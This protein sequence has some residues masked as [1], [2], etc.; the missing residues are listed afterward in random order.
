MKADAVI[1]GAGIVGSTIA[2]ELSKYDIE[3]TVVEKEVD[4][5]FGSPTKA[6]TGVVHPGFDDPPGTTRAKHCSRGNA[7]WHEIAREVGA[8]FEEVGSLVVALKDEEIEVLE[9]LKH[10]GDTNG[11]PGLE[12]VTD[13][14]RLRRIEPNLNTGA[15]AALLAPTAA[16]TSPYELAM[17]MMENAVRN[18]VRTCFETEVTGITVKQDRVRGIQT[19]KGEI[20]TQFVVNAAGLWADKISS[21]V[22]LNRFTIHPR[23]G[24]YYIL[25]KK[26]G[27]LSRHVIFPTPSPISKGIVVT[28]TVE[29]NT[30]I[31]PNAQDIEDKRD[32]ATTRD[33][34]VE[35]WAG[36]CKLIP[37]IAD[38]RNMMVTNFCGLRPE[39]DTNDF[40]VGRSETI[41]GFINAAG[42]RSP[43]L[44][45]AP[46]VA[47]TIVELLRESGAELRQKSTFNPM[48]KP[49]DKP[50][51]ILDS[52]SAQKLIEQDPDY[53]YVVCRCEHV[54]K[55]EI[56]EAIRRGATTV[57]G[58][59]FRTRAG[60]GRCQGGF[61]GPHVLKL[62]SEELKIPA[63]RVTKRGGESR[64]LLGGAK[65]LLRGGDS[66]E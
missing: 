59:K 46:S 22:G 23:K 18:G 2:R 49:M 47:L 20:E 26:A 38:K 40:I 60:M 41:D 15:V 16:I 51:R 66:N 63:Q 35:V 33:G 55:G 61:C 65:E 7:L 4:V 58:V 39:P 3:V 56:L 14:D 8:P 28:P 12:I 24:E 53:G 11:V 62:M 6:N 19:T 29:G 5:A 57:D 13:E 30:L 43:G 50:M 48:R 37:S 1:V 42:M 27:S 21:M 45:S 31:G 34:L 32:L 9:G 36:A 25:D 44:S 17:A 10:R 64:I 52:G 54:T